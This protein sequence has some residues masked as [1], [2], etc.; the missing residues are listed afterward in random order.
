MNKFRVIGETLFNQMQQVWFLNSM[1]GHYT[2]IKKIDWENH[3]VQ[4]YIV[5]LEKDVL[6]FMGAIAVKSLFDLFES[7]IIEDE[8]LLTEL[9]MLLADGMLRE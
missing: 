9:D 4:Y 3:N 1:T 6:V 7:E 5:M 2:R 8:D